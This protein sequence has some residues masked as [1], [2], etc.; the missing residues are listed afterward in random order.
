M[1]PRLQ[2]LLALYTLI[3]AGLA[4]A[5]SSPSQPAASMPAGSYVNPVHAQDFPDPHVVSYRGRFYAYATQKDDRGFQ[6]M[7]S[8]DLV[9]WQ[10]RGAAYR[11]PWSSRHYWAPEVAQYRG[12]FYMTYSAQNPMT[13]K[14]DIGIAIASSPLGP[15]R[16]AAIL[17]RG[18]ANRVGVIDTTLFF[19]RDGSPFLIYSEEDPRRIVMRRMRRDLLA[20]GEEVMELLRPDRE[21]EHGVTEAPT[22]IRRGGRYHLI[23]SAGWYQS[24]RK[25]A[26]Y[27][28][29]HAEAGALRGPYAK[30]PLPL[31]ATIPDQV[32]SPG[33]QCVVQLPSGETWML[34]HAWDNQNE[35][36]Y[37]S[38]PL[39]RTLRLDRL[40]WKGEKPYVDGPS[41]SPRPAPRP[42]K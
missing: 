42:G 8:A 10:H 4:A 17:V 14:H 30:S 34:Y 21:A 2:F 28:V 16:H 13:G 31:L 18:D 38:N 5:V 32:L 9:N 19:E 22:M 1:P 37:G 35:P 40:W 33:H 36:R 15:F 39:G 23:Y 26:N 24:N 27:G 3:A 25:D 20:A 29:Y 11:P 41:T 6:V 7:E 12:R